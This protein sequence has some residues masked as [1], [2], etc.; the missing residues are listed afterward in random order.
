MRRWAQLS[1][2]IVLAAQG[3]HA[4]EIQLRIAPPEPEW[5]SA[6]TSAQPPVQSAGVSVPALDRAAA[7]GDGDPLVLGEPSSREPGAAP[8]VSVTYG[9]EGLLTQPEEQIVLEITPFLVSGNYAAVLGRIRATHAVEL[10][11]LEAGDIEG[12]LRISMPT[13]GRPQAYMTGNRFGDRAGMGVPPSY[14]S[15]TMLYL[16]GQTYFALEQ[17]L[18]AETAFTLALAPLPNHIRAHE[19][20]GMLYLATDRYSEARVHLARAVE[21]GRSTASIHSAL[22]YLEQRTRHYWAAADAFQRALALEPR[23]RAAQRGLLHALTETREHAKALALVE[24]L[25]RDEPDDAAL[26]LYR[27]Q[28]ALSSGARASAVASLETALRLGDD[29]PA[30]RQACIALHIE[31]GNIARAAE[32]LQS[33][34]ARELDFALIEQALDWLANENEWSSFRALLASLDEEPLGV[35][36]Q[37]RLLTRRASL[38]LHDGNRRAASTALQQALALDPANGGALLALGQI[39]RAERD[40]GRADLLLQRAGAYNAFRDDALVARA[41]VA[42]DQQRFDE[43]LMLLRNVVSST[44]AGRER[45]IATLE[46]L[47]LLRTQR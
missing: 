30:N 6:T 14:I 11:R 36:Q 25:L 8:A 13:D 24:Q 20:L 34:S 42:I 16:I 47:V 4:G 26:W 38:A 29:S 22:G 23:H 33:S 15:A 44:S 5:L 21:L 35:V 2:S 31:S 27:A 39:Y 37:S 19:S 18:P 1:V 17:Y 40:Y 46:N 10:S 41:D 3:A 32:L 45:S 12:F 28:I 9:P 7:L 43:A